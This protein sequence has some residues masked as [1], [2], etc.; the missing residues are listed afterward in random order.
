MIDV[1]QGRSSLPAADPVDECGVGSFPASDPPS[2]WA[3]RDG[4]ARATGQPAPD[5]FAARIEPPAGG[6]GRAR[7]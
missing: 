6:A 1:T 2:G 3:G 5:G 4:T 7:S